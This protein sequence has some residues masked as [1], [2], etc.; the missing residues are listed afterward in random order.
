VPDEA[1]AFAFIK[2][3]FKNH[4]RS[5]VQKYAF[6]LKRVVRSRRARMTVPVWIGTTG[7]A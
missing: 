3:A 5:L 2:T 6:T 7:S 1:K 4:V